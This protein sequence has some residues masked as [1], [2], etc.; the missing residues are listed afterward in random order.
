[1]ESKHTYPRALI[2]VWGWKAES[3]K[4]IR[5]TLDISNYLE[6]KTG[7]TIKKLG[8]KMASLKK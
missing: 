1:M 5:N 7:A 8:L 4:G 6:R 2:E 3:G